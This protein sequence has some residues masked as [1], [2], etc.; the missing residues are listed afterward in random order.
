MSGGPAPHSSLWS[1]SGCEPCARDAASIPW[2]AGSPNRRWRVEPLGVTKVSPSPDSAR[3]TVGAAAGEA[4]GFAAAGSA[5]AGPGLD[6]VAASTGAGERVHAVDSSATNASA[7]RSVG[8]MD[9]GTWWGAS[10]SKIGEHTSELQS[11]MRISYAVFC[12]KKT[13]K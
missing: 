1:R 4:G 12:L 6:D 13:K 7:R 3:W 5:G 9:I 11:L 8:R 10:N 2:S